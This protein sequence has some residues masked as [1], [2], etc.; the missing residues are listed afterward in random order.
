MNIPNA[1]S[2]KFEGTK[3]QTF[4]SLTIPSGSDCNN[5]FSIETITSGDVANFSMPAG[6]FNGDWLRITNITAG[7]GAT[8]NATNSLGVGT[9]TG[10]S[11]TSPA[12][13]DLYWIGN[14]G[15]WSNTNNWSLTS[16]GASYG[17][18]P[19]SN[20]NVFFDANSFNGA[21]QS[22][23]IYSTA[24][25]KNMDWT[26][27]TNSPALEGSYQLNINGS[28]TLI[29]SMVI[30]GYSGSINFTSSGAVNTITSAGHTFNGISLSGS[31]TYSLT[32]N[33]TVSWNGLT[34]NNGTFNTSNFDISTGVFNSNSSSVRTLNLGSSNI[35]VENWNI[36]N[37][38]N[39]TLNAGTSEIV[40][41]NSTWQFVGGDLTYNKVTLT[42][43]SWGSILMYD[44]NTFNIL[45]IA[46]GAMVQ[47]EAGETQ[48]TT[49]LEATGSAGN[50]IQ[51]NSSISGSQSFINQT[52]QGFCGDW[53]KVKD[54]SVGTQSFY[55]GEN[56]V[57]LGGNSGWT[58]SGV[59]AIDQ[60][61][62]ALCEDVVGGGTVAN[63]DLTALETTI[64]GGNGSTHTWYSDANL[65]SAVPNPNSVT[66]SN[67]QIFYD[68]VDNGTCTSIAEATYSVKGKAAVGAGIDQEVCEGIQTTLTA[69]N[70]DGASISWD[71]SI[72]DGV[73]FT[74]AVGT[75]TYTVTATLNGCDNTDDVDVTVNPLPT[76][77]AGNDQDVCN[78][79]QTTLTASNPDGA[80]ISWDNSI[81]DGVAFTPALGTTTYTVTATLNGCDNTDA[82]DVTVNPIP[83][84][85][86]G[87][88]QEV[89]DGIQTTLTASNP[90]GASISW[91]NSVTDGVAFTQA[92]G[93][94]TYIVTAT[95]IGCDNTDA[96]DVT[97]NHAPVTNFTIDNS[98]EPIVDLTNTS[99]GADS[100]SWDLGDGTTGVVTT[101]VSHEYTTNNTFTVVL[102]ATNSCGT[103]S[104]Q[105]NVTITNVTITNVNIA[106]V[107]KSDIKIYPNPNNGL[108][109]VELPKDDN[110]LITII[111]I[112]GQIVYQIKSTS[113]Q[114]NINIENYSKGVYFVR[115]VSDSIN[116]TKQIIVE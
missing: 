2:I 18:V 52:T 62:A 46:D 25:C 38:T 6:T 39:L 29:P 37:A 97:V 68:E 51:I 63:V 59:T 32:D 75:I 110:T 66:V 83:T 7:G 43:P 77:G 31:G 82:V 111:N 12:S 28:L 105:Q 56:S 103:I 70:P 109:N 102:Y 60:Y 21:S 35:D 104:T 48:T 26:G 113:K 99:T 79:S 96:V 36:S 23:N 107:N 69:S 47:F 11:I 90:D 89:C 14:D 30:S 92:V 106:S 73:P 45:S 116:T 22:V 101:D 65:I 44:S 67:G 3:T 87:A 20:D 93:T 88:D 8:F 33:L 24:Y 74:Q 115:I 1:N 15:D 108:F 114:N 40:T 41:R 112:S 94:T 13:V 98:N 81:T 71:N 58:W 49:S 55:A 78:G 16:G 27:A 91:D 76:V 95:L 64:D 85:G 54:I 17:C 4:N 53:L 72:T 50:Y 10:W 86:A 9:T 42:K 100:Y 80:S 84:V 61:P 5:Y 34:F 57:D 19:T